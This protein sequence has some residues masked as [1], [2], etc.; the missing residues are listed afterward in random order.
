[1]YSAQE[2][3]QV[4]TGMAQPG[5]GRRHGGEGGD[6]TNQQEGVATMTLPRTHSALPSEKDVGL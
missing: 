2:A 6:D 1:M 4:S 5:M 3:V